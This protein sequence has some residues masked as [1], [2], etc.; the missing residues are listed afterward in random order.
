MHDLATRSRT[1]RHRKT[2]LFW[3]MSC[4]LL[5]GGCGKKEAAPTSATKPMSSASAAKTTPTGVP[6]PSEEP[7]EEVLRKLEF[8]T[9]EAIE[10][11]GGIPVTVSATGKSLT[12]RPKLYEVRKDSCKKSP[13]APAGWYEC[14]LTI[15][16]SLAPDR[17]KPSEQGERI[18]V[19]WDPSGKWVLQ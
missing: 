3:A 17:S 5:L 10:R 15:K 8:Q 1:N 14:S 6:V 11:A 18:G 13:Q 12:L 4:L 9:Y 19:K 16:L 7:S 2:A